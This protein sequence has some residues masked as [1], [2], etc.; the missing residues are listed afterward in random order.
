M[1]D[2]AKYDLSIEDVFRRAHLLTKERLVPHARDVYTEYFVTTVDRDI[3]DET[4]F[5]LK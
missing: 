1:I 4:R 2:I 5:A 3:S